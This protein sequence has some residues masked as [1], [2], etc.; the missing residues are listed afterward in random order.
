M[1]SVVGRELIVVVLV[2][3]VEVVVVVVMGAFRGMLLLTAT[4]AD[5]AM[6]MDAFPSSKI[7]ED[8][9]CILG[10]YNLAQY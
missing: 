2:E 7:G 9:V 10:M 4:V 3:V 8:F 5:G 6:D 1:V